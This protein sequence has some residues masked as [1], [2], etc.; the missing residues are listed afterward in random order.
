MAEGN[1]TPGAFARIYRVLRVVVLLVLIAA[2]LLVFRKSPPPVFDTAP[3]AAETLRAKLVEERKN[4]DTKQPHA[5]KLNEA[6]LN[7]MLASGLQLAPASAPTSS[8]VRDVRVSLLEDRVLAYV[9]FAFHG[10]DLS[11]QLEGQ[12]GVNDGYLH[13]SP[14]A[15]KLGSLPLPQIALNNAVARLFDSA[16]NKEKFRV[17]PEVADIRVS[18]GELVV[19]YR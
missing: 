10:Q 13:F 9:V 5:L 11:L 3:D 2:I 15:G 8:P 14:A 6:E 16:D 19:S 18:G 12:L 4:A 17:P 1:K 7:S